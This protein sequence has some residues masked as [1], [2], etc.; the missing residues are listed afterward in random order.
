[1]EAASENPLRHFVTSVQDFIL[2]CKHSQNMAKKCNLV[3][4]NTARLSLTGDFSFPS[5]DSIWQSYRKTDQAPLY[6]GVESSNLGP[7]DFTC[8]GISF[9]N[10]RTKSQDD[11]T[12]EPEAK[13]KKIIITIDTD[14]SL[15]NSTNETSAKEMSYHLDASCC[16]G[17]IE[18][19][20][21][22][23][24]EWGI[25]IQRISVSNRIALY[26]NR[27]ATFKFIMQ[28]V[29][30]SNLTS[31]PNNQSC[32]ASF[33]VFPKPFSDKREELVAIT[34]DILPTDD[35]SV[36]EYRLELVK[37]VLKN[38]INASSF[39][40]AEPQNLCEADGN[41]VGL[42]NLIRIHLTTK[43]SVKVKADKSRIITVGNLLDPTL[44][45]KLSKVKAN[46]YIQ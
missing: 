37:N 2:N 3:K 40:L 27:T 21:E 44:Q 41:T 14:G 22:A 16:I 11:L 5:D 31:D 38:L 1:M 32:R 36:T 29:L 10:E 34:S 18:R 26:L 4:S 7:T 25:P 43:P 20:V 17:S 46:D 13:P 9:S 8:S 30:G 12:T 24:K 15:T 39:N 42:S 19:F 35:E 23:S 33:G 28:T 6:G 45:N